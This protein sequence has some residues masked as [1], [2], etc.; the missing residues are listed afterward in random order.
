MDFRTIRTKLEQQEY[1]GSSR[2]PVVSVEDFFQEHQSPLAG[3]AGLAA[4]F[5]LMC[6]NALWFNEPGSGAHQLAK[7]LRSKGKLA[8]RKQPA[9]P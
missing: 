3:V 8:F 1:T 4:D 7:K 6:T 9:M 5:E 2:P